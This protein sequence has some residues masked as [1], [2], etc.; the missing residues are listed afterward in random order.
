MITQD[1]INCCNNEN[2]GINIYTESFSPENVVDLTTARIE[3][4]AFQQVLQII[5]ARGNATNPEP[6]LSIVIKNGDV[7]IPDSITPNFI[8][9]KEFLALVPEYAHCAI[10]GEFT[11]KSLVVGINVTRNYPEIPLLVFDV[12]ETAMAVMIPVSPEG[13]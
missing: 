6:D 7:E 13:D 11:S 4:I 1:V 10:N 2:M 5:P 8:P 12:A 9:L 3:E